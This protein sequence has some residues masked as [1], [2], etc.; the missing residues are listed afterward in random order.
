[1]RAYIEDFLKSVKKLNKTD[2]EK[3][4]LIANQLDFD[5]K[6]YFEESRKRKLGDWK[7]G[8]LKSIVSD[9]QFKK[10]ILEARSEACLNIPLYDDCP[11]MN[12]ENYDEAED[13]LVNYVF[14]TWAKSNK[15]PEAFFSSRS[16]IEETIR[17]SAYTEVSGIIEEFG[18][19]DGWRTFVI[20]YI[21][22]PKK[23]GKNLKV[24][25]DLNKRINVE[26]VDGKS[27]YLRIDKGVAKKD[28]DVIG[29]VFQVFLN[30]DIPTELLPKNTESNILAHEFEKSGDGKKS[31]RELAKDKYSKDYQK[32]TDDYPLTTKTMAHMNTT[33]RVAKKIKRAKNRNPEYR[34]DINNGQ[35]IGKILSNERK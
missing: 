16:T 33:S 13:F 29:D 21:L 17:N 15:N 28:L 30:F 6:I 7:S 24:I 5:A 8:D 23:I 1:M 9:K 22:N 31:Y 4:K 18:L 19:P 2:E 35:K 26:K 10:M 25:D 34:S 27:L 12:F 11:I 32:E 3:F 14:E 20:A